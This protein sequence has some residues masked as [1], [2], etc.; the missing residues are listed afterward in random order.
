MTPRKELYVK[1]RQA[2]SEIPQ[3]EYID[4]YRNQFAANKEYYPQYWTAA[5]IRIN[6]IQFESMVEGRQE[7]NAS[8]D[9]YLYTKD[10]WLDQH[11][12]T[13]D[14]E[15]GL[16]EIDLID[17]IAEKLQFLSGDLFTPL[18]QT[19]DEVEDNSLDGIMSYKLNFSSNIYRRLKYPYTNKRI[20]VTP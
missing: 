3:L 9:I 4:V 17:A 1:I 14:A 13:A 8:I 5:L 20:T 7:G 12:G 15:G 19:G 6:N 10:G 18:H 16:I 11:Q 2:L